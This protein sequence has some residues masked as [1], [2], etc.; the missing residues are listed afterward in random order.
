MPK[1]SRYIE[2]EKETRE[3]CIVFIEGNKP[4][5]GEKIGQ[6]VEKG[7]NSKLR[8]TTVSWIHL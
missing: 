7:S 1:L 8:R 5:T 6:H 3:S 2:S 4:D